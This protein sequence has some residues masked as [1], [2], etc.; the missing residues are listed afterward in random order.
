M[1]KMHLR[2]EATHPAL[3]AVEAEPGVYRRVA[4]AV[5]I[6]PNVRGDATANH[7]AIAPH[8]PGRILVRYLEQ[9]I[10]EEEI[11]K[12][13]EDMTMPSETS[14]TPDQ[15]LPKILASRPQDLSPQNNLTRMHLPFP[16]PLRLQVH[17]SINP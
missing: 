11:L 7:Q 4:V 1:T 15:A 2:A 8:R 9:E 17:L 10:L 12:P 13:C 14:Q 16:L 3:V 6:V 5:A